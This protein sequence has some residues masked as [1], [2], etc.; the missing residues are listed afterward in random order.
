[1]IVKRMKYQTK[2]KFLTIIKK[3]QEI[4]EDTNIC[5][6]EFQKCPN[7]ELSKLKKAM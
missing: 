5:P 6:N 2:R 3:I 4:K 1:M 7:K